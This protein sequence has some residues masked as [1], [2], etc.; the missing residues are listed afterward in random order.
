L[1]ADERQLFCRLGI[2]AG[3][4]EIHAAEAISPPSEGSPARV[5]DALAGLVDRSL[6]LVHATAAGT[7]WYRLLEP[8][9]QHA[10]ERL[11]ADG[12]YEDGRV[13]GCATA[14]RALFQGVG[15]RRPAS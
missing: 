13:R 11:V 14:A 4:S 2:F 15:R 6:L 1:A 3:S 12:V 9:R 7:H 5:L 10:L 8:V